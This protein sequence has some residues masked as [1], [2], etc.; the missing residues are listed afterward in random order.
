[1]DL[2]KSIVAIRYCDEKKK[3]S[4]LFHCWPSKWNPLIVNVSHILKPCTF[5]KYRSTLQS[6]AIKKNVKV[7]QGSTKELHF[8]SIN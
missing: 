7:I 3:V 4:V 5:I 6:C 2:C 1:M 8:V